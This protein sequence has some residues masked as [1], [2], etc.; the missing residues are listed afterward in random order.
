MPENTTHAEMTEVNDDLVGRFLSFCV[1]DSLYAL[2][3]LY[4]KEI[5]SMQQITVVPSL[6][7]YI[8]GIINLRGKVVP[9]IDVRIKLNQPNPEYNEK[10]CIIITEVN[11]MQVGLIVDGV[12]EVVSSSQSEKMVPPDMSVM[13]EN[14]IHSI[15][16]LYDK[17][18]VL[19]LDCDK[20]FAADL[21]L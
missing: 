18:V 10:T 12:A 20:F 5:I 15:M 16:H 19:C 4:V 6:P 14:Y 21:K 9:V 8:K 13:G 2:E 7:H 1:G 17:R 11:D 3:L